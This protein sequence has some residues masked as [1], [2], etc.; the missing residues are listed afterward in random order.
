MHIHGTMLSDTNQP[1]LV[2]LRQ[3]VVLDGFAFV[4]RW[5]RGVTTDELATRIGT[6]LKLGKATVAH[7]IVPKRTDTPNT[8]SGMYG[9][10]EF[11]LHTDMAHWRDPPRYMML[12][13]VR[14]HASVATMVLDG[15]K[16]ID[17]IGEAVLARSLVRPR[18]PIR[19]AFH[20]LSLYRA[21][22]S[23]TEPLLRWDEA[24]IV[25]A[26]PAG[27][28]GTELVRS[29]LGQIEPIH[30]SL[31]DPGDTLIIDNWRMLHGRS[32]LTAI[33]ANRIVERVYMGALI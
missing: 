24:F 25:P 13:C 9:F 20:L 21:T 8:Y 7:Q 10:S 33:E 4:P 28:E 22:R 1:D 5:E 29:V 6:A 32:A 12:R 16:L 31:A 11:P 2:A 23:G 17:A 19:G 14:G 27:V 26:S 15:R 30:F 3:A 18:R